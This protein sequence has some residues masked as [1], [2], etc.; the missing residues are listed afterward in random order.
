MATSSLPALF[1]CVYDHVDRY[2]TYERVGTSAKGRAHV[3]LG[4][5]QVLLG[6]LVSFQDM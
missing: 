4:H 1:Q 2:S 5:M 3:S 6:H